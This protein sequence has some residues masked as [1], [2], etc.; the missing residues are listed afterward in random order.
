MAA[1]VLLLA[2]CTATPVSTTDI[3]ALT[4]H[5]FQAIENF[6][7]SEYVQDDPAEI[8][9]FV[10]LLGEH[11][12]VPG[13]TVTA[14]QDYCDGGISTTVTVEYADGAEADMFIARCGEEQYSE[15]NSLSNELFSEWREELAG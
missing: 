8:A 10:A 15:F 11:N 2:G 9:R 5:Q 1:V 7:D 12:V 13:R 3:V 6:D 4:F 14:K